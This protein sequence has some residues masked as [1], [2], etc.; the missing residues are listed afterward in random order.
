[1]N[2]TTLE[3]FQTALREFQE[4]AAV[5]LAWIGQKQN[6]CLEWTVSA[7]QWE[8]AMAHPENQNKNN[9]QTL[10]EMKTY[11]TDAKKDL[12][13]SLQWLEKAYQKRCAKA[14]AELTELAALTDD[15]ASRR[16]ADAYCEAYEQ[17]LASGQDY[18][19]QSPQE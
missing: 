12:E 6:D 9:Q 2:D 10:Q 3:R 16:L 18:G 14:K 13:E 11:L 4:D 19:L 7:N 15:D 1:M 5:L 8:A 17:F